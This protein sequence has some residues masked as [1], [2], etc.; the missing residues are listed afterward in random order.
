VSAHNDTLKGAVQ[1]LVANYI[2]EPS[3]KK[4]EQ[5]AFEMKLRG[6]CLLPFF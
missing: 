4:R 6:L 5:F 1:N 3:A 2:E